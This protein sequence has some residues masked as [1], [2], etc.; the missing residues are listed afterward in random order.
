MRSSKKVKRYPSQRNKGKN[1]YNNREEENIRYSSDNKMNTNERGSNN[2]NNNNNN[3]VHVNENNEESTQQREWRKW[4]ETANK[5]RERMR[6]IRPN[7]K[8]QQQISTNE[9]ITENEP[10]ATNP[11]GTDESERANE[12]NNGTNRTTMEL[13]PPNNSSGQVQNKNSTSQATAS[14]VDKQNHYTFVT[15]NVQGL[16]DSSDYKLEHIIRLMK[17]EQIDCFLIQETHQEKDTIQELGQGYTFIHHGPD[18][19]PAQGAKGGIGIILSPEFTKMWRKGGSKIEY[20]EIIAGTTRLMRVDIDVAIFDKAE[21]N[22]KQQKRLNEKKVIKNNNNK[23]IYS[24]VNS[25]HPHT[26]Y[27]DEDADHHN[28]AVTQIC[29]NCPKEATLIMGADINAALG[30][31]KQDR[32]NEQEDEND[33]YSILGPYLKKEMKEEKKF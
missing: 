26:G 17:K 23:L 6:E 32:G 8:Q 19:Q 28:Q 16:R 5:R 7:N 9:I 11:D 4:Y 29:E 22:K 15:Q 30:T 21:I 13:P 33:P 31:N 10:K 18:T 20:G 25:Y 3:N 2:N 1:K 27:S 14:F 12:E 24:I